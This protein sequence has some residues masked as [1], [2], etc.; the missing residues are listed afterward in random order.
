M[1]SILMDTKQQI[2]K[3]LSSE[4][5]N[6]YPIVLT[7]GHSDEEEDQMLPSEKSH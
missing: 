4:E 3:P 5:D 7:T 2:K 6:E 1:G